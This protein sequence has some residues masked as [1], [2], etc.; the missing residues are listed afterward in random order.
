MRECDRYMLLENNC[1]KYALDFC[2][3]LVGGSYELPN[4]PQAG[5]DAWA[6]GPGAHAV[7]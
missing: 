7:A 5:T 4:L 1:Q 6:S 3:F 2:Q